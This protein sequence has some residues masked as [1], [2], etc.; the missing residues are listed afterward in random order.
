MSLTRTTQQIHGGKLAK[1][2]ISSDDKKAPPLADAIA[3][4]VRTAQEIGTP[5]HQEQAAIIAA[6]AK[7]RRYG[8]AML[9]AWNLA[10][11]MGLEYGQHQRQRVRIEY[12]KQRQYGAA[13]SAG[14]RSLEAWQA[15]REAIRNEWQSVRAEVKTD[16]AAY[17]VMLDRHGRSRSTVERAIGKR[18]QRGTAPVGH[19]DPREY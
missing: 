6:H 15:E 12:R 3:L 19:A 1:V 18:R 14:H 2:D 5:A 16:K 4:I 9:A 8:A 7:A 17:A 13:V 10:A 11:E